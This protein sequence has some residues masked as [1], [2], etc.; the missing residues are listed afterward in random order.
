MV[1]ALEKN[2]GTDCEAGYYKK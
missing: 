1:E 2:E